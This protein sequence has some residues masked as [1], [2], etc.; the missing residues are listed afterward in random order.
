[1]KE[2]FRLVYISE[3]HHEVCYTDL[4]NILFS[5]RN[6]NSKLDITGILIHR[7]DF[8]IQL[9]EGPE[10]HVKEVLSLIIKDRRHKNLRVIKEW[11]STQPRYFDKWAMS[12]IDGDLEEKTHPFIQEIFSN[13]M[14]IDL[15][16][17][18]QFQTFFTS[19]SNNGI[20]LK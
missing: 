12:F 8:F 7:D 14:L 11:T 17:E 10:A 5:A 1:M 3:A 19:I 13:T 6:R 4:E 18:N 9:L 20:E 16:S 15:P 2:I